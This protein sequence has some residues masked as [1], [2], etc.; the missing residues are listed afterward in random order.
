MNVLF[1]IFEV[2]AIE[3]VIVLATALMEVIKAEAGIPVAVGFIPTTY[4]VTLDILIVVLGDLLGPVVWF[5]TV[6]LVMNAGIEYAAA[7]V[8]AGEAPAT[9]PYCFV[10]TCKPKVLTVAVAAA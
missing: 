8:A 1:E 2:V 7:V 6:Q 3:I 9:A 10:A 5:E 4:P